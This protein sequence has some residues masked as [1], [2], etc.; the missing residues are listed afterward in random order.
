MENGKVVNKQNQA[1][2][3]MGNKA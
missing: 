3:K 2:S 1:A